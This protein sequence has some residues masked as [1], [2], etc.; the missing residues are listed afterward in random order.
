[1]KEKNTNNK[2]T[3]KK[4]KEG[5]YNRATC[6]KKNQIKNV[7]VH[8]TMKLGINILYIYPSCI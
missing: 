8:F 4:R 2:N 1:M 6:K 5:M 7:T 3:K